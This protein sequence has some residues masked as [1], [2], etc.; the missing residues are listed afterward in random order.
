MRTRSIGLR[1]VLITV[2]VGLLGAGAAAWA[3]EMEV[4]FDRP[5]G[6]LSDMDLAKADP[7]LCRAACEKDGRCLAWT[8]M[9][10]APGEA[11]HCYLKS[12][13]PEP[14][15]HERC[16]SGVRRAGTA[17]QAGLEPN[18]NRPGGDFRD[19]ALDSPDPEL[20][21]R[22]CNRDLRCQAWT[23]VRPAGEGDAP[24]C[25]LKSER[26][27][28]VFDEACVSGVKPRHGKEIPKPERTPEQIRL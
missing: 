28:P 14:V 20:C 25:W 16:T 10:P 3:Q 21:Q 22:A 26:P 19:L 23:Y 18:T 9:A 6:D 24:H 11:P 7:A 17:D 12:E 4:G 13:V 8:Y 5:G 1:W 27:D 15:E 2:A